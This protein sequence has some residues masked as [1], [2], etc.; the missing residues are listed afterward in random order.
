MLYFPLSLL[1]YKA[2]QGD[3]IDVVISGYSFKAMQNIDSLLVGTGRRASSLLSPCPNSSLNRTE[4]ILLV[5]VL[6][7]K[8]HLFPL[9][10]AKGQGQKT[11]T[12]PPSVCYNISRL[13]AEIQTKFPALPRP[14]VTTAGRSK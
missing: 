5:L 2:D 11:S 10:I 7:F 1:S 14:Q 13:M 12:K 6:I 8:M 3:I 4:A 9:L